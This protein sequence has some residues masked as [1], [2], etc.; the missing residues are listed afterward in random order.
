MKNPDCP[1]VTWII[2]ADHDAAERVVQKFRLLGV[3]EQ[4]L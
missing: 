1:L 2:Y 4:E 3:N